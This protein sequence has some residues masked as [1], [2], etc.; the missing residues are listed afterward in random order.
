MYLLSQIEGSPWQTQWQGICKNIKSIMDRLHWNVL[1]THFPVDEPSLLETVMNFAKFAN[2]V[3]QEESLL[4]VMS[5]WSFVL[6]HSQDKLSYLRTG[7]AQFMLNCQYVFCCTGESCVVPTQCPCEWEG[8]LFPPG[9][10]ITQHCQN[11][12][13]NLNS[14]G[15]VFPYSYTLLFSNKQH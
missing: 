13:V 4:T 8:S 14:H 10:T 11:W 9:T 3:A 6:S 12:S 7:K 15:S 5:P 2:K 1:C